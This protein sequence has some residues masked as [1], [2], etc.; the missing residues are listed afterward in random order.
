M[1]KQS[2]QLIQRLFKQLSKKQLRALASLIIC[3]AGVSAG[4]LVL[5]VLLADLVSTLASGGGVP[6]R[7]LVLGVIAAAWLTSLARAG[8]K[9]WES[10]LIYRIW[11]SLNNTLL[12]NLLYQPYSFYLLNDRN[13]LSTRLQI[14]LSQLRDNIIKPLIEATSSGVTAA[15]LGSGLL[16][17]TGKGSLLAL[18]VVLIGYG[19]QV[20]KLKPVLQ[21][22]RQKIIQAELESN[23][24]ILDTLG[25]IRRLLMERGQKT[26][27]SEK[28]ELDEKIVTSASWSH[29]LPHLPRQLVE[30][31]GLT[32][33]LL[34]LQAPSIRS[35][36]S[37]A[38]PW[39]ALVTLGLLRLSQPMQNLSE[40]YNRLQA[41]IPL[42]NNLLPLLELPI[43]PI[44]KEQPQKLPWKELHLDNIWQKY[45]NAVRWTLQELNLTLRRGEI[46]AIVGASGSG[47]STL[48]AIL[49]GLLS[50]DKGRI[51]IDKKPLLFDRIHSWQF[52]CSEVSQ[53][54]N[55]LKGSVR[56]NLGGWSQPAPETE[57][58][59]ALEQVGLRKRVEG[60]PQGLDSWVGD[61][62]KGWSSGEQQRLAFAATVLRKPEL[63]VLD[64]ATSGVQEA[65]AQNMICSLKN[66]PQ[67]PT[68]VV[69]THRESIM[70]CC[71][72]V[73]LVKQG[74][75]VA[76]G[77]FADLKEE[78]SELR[79]LLVQ[80]SEHQTS[81][82]T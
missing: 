53:S 74:A 67:Q 2:D 33:V 12:S 48:S 25:N 15:L 46:I 82:N 47:K 35:N 16:W 50:P 57:L 52:Q 34:L 61:H 9:L 1:N 59:Q 22:H 79:S 20:L 19:L 4:D 31:L 40:S 44:I 43:N 24:L 71:E 45:P 63:I 21:R 6:I 54:P 28:N 70:R 8:I 17:L 13:E 73:L 76:D 72:R 56:T 26:V 7:N 77:P 29:V 64:E 58:L 41:G 30:P 39:L 3:S 27:L 49:I 14:Q 78:C 55:L 69:I 68:V 38:L 60:L 36:G 66:Q 18:M 42:L 32:V 5:V 11:E 10:Q 65:L 51:F 37:D 81:I 75:I 80:T 62:G 23:N